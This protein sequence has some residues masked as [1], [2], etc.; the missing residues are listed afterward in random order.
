MIRGLHLNNYQSQKVR[1]I[2]LKVAEQIT[3]IEAQYAGNQKK[4]DDLT[5]KALAERDQYLES[6]LS[7]VQYNDY[8]N[9]REEYVA[10]DKEFMAEIKPEAPVTGDALS[11]K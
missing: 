6:V 2:N 10:I 5:K 8:Y 3:S 7:T 1:E 9:Q 4:I 11:S